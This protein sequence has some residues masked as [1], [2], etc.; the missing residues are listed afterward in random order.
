MPTLAGN[1]NSS[2][3]NGYIHHGERKIFSEYEYPKPEIV[4]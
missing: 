1:L 3:V 4:K 2:Q